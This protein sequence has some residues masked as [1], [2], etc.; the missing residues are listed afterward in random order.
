MLWPGK[1]HHVYQQSSLVDRAFCPDSLWGIRLQSLDFKKHEPCETEPQTVGS[2]EEN[3]RIGV[4]CD[5]KIDDRSDALK[6]ARQLTKLDQE[7]LADALLEAH[8]EGIDQAR[9]LFHQKKAPDEI[10][11]DLDRR[12]DFLLSQLKSK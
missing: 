12:R 6:A 5:V 3:A 11:K 1:V 4:I 8:L 9:I 7:A 2:S 10:S